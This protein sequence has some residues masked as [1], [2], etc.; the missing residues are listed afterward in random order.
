MT[1]HHIGDPTPALHTGTSVWAEKLT[2]TGFVA[3]ASELGATKTGGH[4]ESAQLDWMAFLP[5][6]LGPG[7]L[8]QTTEL[9][10]F[11]SGSELTHPLCGDVDLRAQGFT[12]TPIVHVSVVYR[13]T[14]VLGAGIPITVWMEAVS[15]TSFRYCV[16]TLAGFPRWVSGVMLHWAAYE[17][18]PQGWKGGALNI[19]AFAGAACA[20]A[21]IGC[22]DA[23]SCKLDQR[24]LSI[25]HPG[26]TADH[27]PVSAWIESVEASGNLRLCVAETGRADGS[28]AA[29]TLHWAVPAF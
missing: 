12:E 17:H 7:V 11:S 16:D 1:L 18:L 29:L 20:S 13:P 9:L 19:P 15:A 14:T 4:D 25:S 2:D 27:D 26:A 21:H 8:A 24:M 10:E 6:A 5:G 3:C 28:H 23:N 22:A